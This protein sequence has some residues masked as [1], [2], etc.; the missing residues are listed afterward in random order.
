MKSVTD[1]WGAYNASMDVKA[2]GGAKSTSSNLMWDM[3]LAWSPDFRDSE[4]LPRLR[5][6]GFTVVGLTIGTDR[7]GRP[8]PVRD[9]IAEIESLVARDERFMI[10][11]SGQDVLIAQ[12][13][14]K[15]GLELNF[16]G[17]RM[18][19]GDV[20][21]LQIFHALGVRHIGLVWNEANEAGGSSTDDDDRGLTSYGR[22]LIREME[23]V[24]MVADGAHAGYRTTMDAI[25]YSERPFIISHTNC[26]A[27][28][29]SY[30]NALDDQMIACAKTGGVVGI[31]GFGNYLGDPHATTES[32]FRHI[33]YAVEL[34]GP[35]HVGLGLD[36]VTKPG[37]FW[38]MVGR[39]PHIWP[40]P[41]EGSMRPCRFMSH[42]QINGLQAM[43]IGHG[44][45]E[46]D[47]IG[48]LG[49]NWLR[50]CLSCWGA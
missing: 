13:T 27:L 32:F 28:D 33:D 17:T 29:S 20:G 35:E 21:Q 16:Q 11:R 10:I 8:G 42:E 38:E 43:M 44:Y 49:R 26:H 24:G 36:Y 22:S 45:R 14:G 19:G 7:D 5:N 2:S 40:G 1:G 50:V 46:D 34:I 37:K 41:D 48:I 9:S 25:E 3:T 30:K 15:L 39:S 18:L 6:L 31:S 47:V 4:T 12:Q 23:R